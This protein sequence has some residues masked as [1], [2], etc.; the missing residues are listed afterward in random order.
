MI[1]SYMIHF[2][3]HSYMRDKFR[4]SLAHIFLHKV[5]AARNFFIVSGIIEKFFTLPRYITREM[6]TGAI[7]TRTRTLH[8]YIYIHSALAFFRPGES[9]RF[10]VSFLRIYLFF[11]AKSVRRATLRLFDETTIKNIGQFCAGKT[12]LARKTARARVFPGT[13]RPARKCGFGL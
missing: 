12:L 1:F 9:G 5:T 10:F 6:C 2:I 7:R 13:Y 4:S 11:R 3:S 8:I